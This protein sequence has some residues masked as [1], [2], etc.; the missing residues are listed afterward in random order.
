M[1]DPTATDGQLPS[2]TPQIHDNRGRDL[3]REAVFPH[4][5]PS[6]ALRCVNFWCVRIDGAS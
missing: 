1:T 4:V 5:H 2:P 3:L 6:R